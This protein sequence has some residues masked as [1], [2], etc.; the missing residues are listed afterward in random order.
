LSATEMTQSSSTLSMAMTMV[1]A[2]AS[3]GLS[4][5]SPIAV[6]RVYPDCLMLGRRMSAL[7]V[8]SLL[9]SNCSVGGITW[10]AN[11]IGLRL[12]RDAMCLLLLGSKFCPSPSLRTNVCSSEAKALTIVSQATCV[13]QVGV[14]LPDDTG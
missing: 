13:C 5:R 3:R 12:D 10:S 6:S 8:F 7:G 14:H 4:A 9:N 11:V 2:P 1:S